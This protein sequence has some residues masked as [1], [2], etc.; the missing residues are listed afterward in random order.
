MFLNRSL[1]QV[2]I[3]AQ[4]KY[5]GGKKEGSW[6]R[7]GVRRR[8]MTKT[9]CWGRR[10]EAKSWAVVWRLLKPW[11]RYISSSPFT[12]RSRKFVPDPDLNSDLSY[13]LPVTLSSAPFTSL[14]GH[15]TAH[16]GYHSLPPLLRPPKKAFTHIL[17]S[18]FARQFYPKISD[19]RIRCFYTVLFL[20]FVIFFFSEI[21]QHM[22]NYCIL[23]QLFFEDRDRRVSIG[24]VMERMD[25]CSHFILT[26]SMIL[27]PC[28]CKGKRRWREGLDPW[29]CIWDIV[30]TPS[31]A[32]ARVRTQAVLPRLHHLHLLLFRTI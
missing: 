4:Q 29:L 9:E 21:Q 8:S 16:Q 5:D 24:G 30:T 31:D 26:I 22:Q 2:D 7:R 3:N 19:N 12:F 6:S 17:A 1:N 10:W 32:Q 18:F 25:D 23:F 11:P 15:I 13:P 14:Q 27:R 28:R 20:Y